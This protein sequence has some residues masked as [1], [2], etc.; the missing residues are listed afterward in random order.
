MGGGGRLGGACGGAE[1]KAGAGFRPSGVGSTHPPTV[2]C[3]HT[4]PALSTPC[5]L[6]AQ[7]SAHPASCLYPPSPCLSLPGL[8]GG[9]GSHYTHPLTLH[10]PTD[11]A[12]ATH[13]L[14]PPAS[15]PATGPAGGCSSPPGQH[16]LAQ[17]EAGGQLSASP[18]EGGV[19]GGGGMPR[20]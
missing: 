9:C 20:L 8:G 5:I 12:V 18:G 10:P 3:V 11:P 17:P 15:P 6:L 7:R 13:T 1:R 2:S 14:S 19:V 16:S 4:C